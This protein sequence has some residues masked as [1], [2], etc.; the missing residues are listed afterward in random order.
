MQADFQ[1]HRIAL[2]L[3]GAII[4]IWLIAFLALLAFAQ[5]GDGE[6]GTAIAV[7]PPSWGADQALA[8]SHA[9]EARLVTTTAF[10]NILVVA[11]D[12][13]G[14]VARLKHNGALMMFRNLA[15]GEISFAGCLGGSL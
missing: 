14:L 5:M 1:P 6:N 2:K 12:T 13:P 8:A 11:D 7:Y 9:A 10:D 3:F 4:A 15:L